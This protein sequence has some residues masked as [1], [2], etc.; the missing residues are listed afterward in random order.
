[1]ADVRHDDAELPELRLH[2]LA[3][4]DPGRPL[5]LLLHGFPEFSGAWERTL[6]SLGEDWF[7]VAPDM[8]GYNLSD[9]PEGVKNYRTRALIGD[10][11]A[12]AD[13]FGKETFLLVGHDWGGAPAWGAAAALPERL[14]GLV[15]LNSP[16]PYIFSRLLAEDAAQI[17]ASQYMRMLRAPDAEETLS[18][19]G[20]EALWSF[21]FARWAE[22]RGSPDVTR[23]RY[24]EAW[25]RP[26]A[27]T[28][29]LNYY[30]ASPIRP[31]APDGSDGP[32]ELEPE[33]FR[34][35][36]PTLVL[37]GEKDRMLL[38]ANIEGL[39]DFVDELE[40]RRFPQASHWIV[41]EEPEAIASAIAEFAA[42]RFSRA[43]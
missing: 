16:H 24:V 8:R 29:M 42:R 22:K 6:A 37:W 43:T 7:A 36:V 21:A 11:M 39:E 26:G 1:M 23:E 40:I 15:I 13:H 17:E 31:P 4:G 3:A 18:A 35:H 30:R 25:S 34:V 9:K 20:F 5:I 2:Y 33:A 10:V 28:A 19:D 27:L 32:P 12:L 14:N 41:H 38:R